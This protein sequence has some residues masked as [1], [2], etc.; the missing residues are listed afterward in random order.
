MGMVLGWNSSIP[1]KKRLK[2]LDPPRGVKWMVSGATK[3]LLRVQMPPLGGC[4]RDVHGQ[5]RKD[6]KKH[7]AGIV[8][9]LVD[10]GKEFFRNRKVVNIF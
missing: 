5:H 10:V 8:F 7:V 9:L 6:G 4:W 2:A 1:P 3:Q